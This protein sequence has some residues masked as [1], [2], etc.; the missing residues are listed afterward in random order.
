MKTRD[1]PLSKP[2]ILLAHC[3]GDGGVT[4]FI[5]MGQQVRARKGDDRVELFGLI[6]TASAHLLQCSKEAKREESRKACMGLRVVLTLVSG[7]V[8]TGDEKFLAQAEE[9][10]K[11]IARD[12]ADALRGSELGWVIDTLPSIELARVY[13]RNA[14]RLADKLGLSKVIPILNRV[15]NVVFEVGRLEAEKVVLSLEELYRGSST[16]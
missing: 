13:I 14:E 5:F 10:L 12:V 6:D 8:A 9:L 1:S 3:P 4:T 11:K 2:C 15:S 7:Y 16:S